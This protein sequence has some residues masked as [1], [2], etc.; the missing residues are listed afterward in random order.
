[1]R[2]IRI[3]RKNDITHHILSMQGTQPESCMATKRDQETRAKQ[4]T[5]GTW[6][7]TV[8]EFVSKEGSWYTRAYE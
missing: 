4:L 2:V 3:E 7:I 8:H 5:T 6:N 1:M